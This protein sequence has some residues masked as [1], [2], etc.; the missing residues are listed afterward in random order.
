MPLGTVER[1][2]ADGPARLMSDAFDDEAWLGAEAQFGNALTLARAAIAFEDHLRRRFGDFEFEPANQ[3][4]HLRFPFAV[5][6]Q[7]SPGWY[8]EKVH[9]VPNMSSTICTQKLLFSK[10]AITQIS[11]AWG[12]G[13]VDGWKQN[14]REAP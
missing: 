10:K 5:P 11:A 12:G 4:R 2:E 3:F 1:F 7:I 13:R 6:D 8:G 14:W 9:Y